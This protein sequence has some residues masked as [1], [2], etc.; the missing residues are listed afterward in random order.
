LIVVDTGPLVAIVHE[1]DSHH[2][3]CQEWF[4]EAD[5][6]KLVI[7]ASVV[8]EACYHI[9]RDLGADVES[10]FLEDL[11]EGTYGTVVGLLPE[12]IRRMSVLVKQYADMPLG[13]T[14]ASVI[15]VA[16]RL[17]TTQVATVDRRHFTVVR[18]T[19]VAAFDLLPVKL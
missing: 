2:T 5:P 12:D 14:D 16:E 7:P 4:L 10:A 6:D 13:G 17:Q 19:H 3:A 18:P 1:H 8:A 15:A 9:G 11:A